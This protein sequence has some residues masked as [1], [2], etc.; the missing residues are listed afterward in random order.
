MDHSK[1]LTSRS[2]SADN[3]KQLNMTT[4]NEVKRSHFTMPYSPSMPAP[5][6]NL[7]NLA[8]GSEGELSELFD[9]PRE[10]MDM[11]S[12]RL[13]RRVHGS[14]L[15]SHDHL[16]WPR[17]LHSIWRYIQPLLGLSD[18]EFL[19]AP[20]LYTPS[21]TTHPSECDLAL[22]PENRVGMEVL[23]G[24]EPEVE[25]LLPV[26]NLI[27]IRIGSNNSNG[28]NLCKLE[29]DGHFPE[30]RLALGS[31]SGS[32]IIITFEFEEFSFMDGMVHNPTRL[33][34][35]IKFDRTSTLKRF[36]CGGFVT[37]IL[38]LNKKDISSNQNA[39]MGATTSISKCDGWLLQLVWV[40]NLAHGLSV[41]T[42][43]SPGSVGLENGST[44]LL[45]RSFCG[46]SISKGAFGL[47]KIWPI[48]KH[49]VTSHSQANYVA[50]ELFYRDYVNGEDG[51]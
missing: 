21:P 33:K 45:T 37:S 27:D 24:V 41:G 11:Y 25:S 9:P 47:R 8:I 22:V 10:A 43:G 16:E 44:R 4:P 15:S 20:D 31:K 42:N 50:D 1:Q 3:L 32:R 48:L 49:F 19:C 35:F 29:L 30:R 18:K 34:E 5:H 23:G 36:L 7:T 40:A 14:N 39:L 13:Q 38:E 12:I 26:T 46:I 6:T 17:R 51:I 2:Y 28:V